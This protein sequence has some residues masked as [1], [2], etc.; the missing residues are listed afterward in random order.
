MWLQTQTAKHV[1]AAILS[2]SQLHRVVDLLGH[3]TLILQAYQEFWSD[4]WLQYDCTFRQKA[5]TFK[6][7]TWA[8]IDTTIWSLAFLWPWK[9]RLIGA[10]PGEK[11]LCLQQPNAWPEARVVGDNMG[12]S[13]LCGRHQWPLDPE[14]SKSICAELAVAEGA[15]IPIPFEVRLWLL[16]QTCYKH[17]VYNSTYKYTYCI[18][19]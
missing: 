8:A 18:L 15:I 12:S 14:H 1:S 4:F 17:I 2:K 13:L 9:I 3:Q 6:D 5:S 10:W 19:N 7:V 16:L 11:L